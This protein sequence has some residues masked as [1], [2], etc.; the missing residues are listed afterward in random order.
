MVTVEELKFIRNPDECWYEC[1]IDEINVF[2]IEKLYQS[3]SKYFWVVK[4]GHLQGN[5]YGDP[6]PIFKTKY[7]KSAKNFVKLCVDS[8]HNED[9]EAYK[10][11]YLEGYGSSKI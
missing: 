5:S 9:Y 1:E 6:Y 10:Y 8:M 11:K 4:I 7:L 2:F 3:N